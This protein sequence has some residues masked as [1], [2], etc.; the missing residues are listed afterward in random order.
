[1]YFRE[2]TVAG[3]TIIIQEKVSSRVRGSQKRK[4][5]MN[6]TSEAMRKINDRNAERDLTVKLNH[7]FKKGDYHLVLTYRGE[8]PE[9]KK[10]K[11]CLEKF[12]R[13]T[14]AY[15]K[16]NNI[17][18]KYI[19]VTEYAHTRIHHHVVMS[20]IDLEVIDRLWKY[21]Y[22]KPTLLD[23]TGNYQKLAAYLLKETS[24][25]FRNEDN[26]NKR[27]YNC[28][29]NIVTPETKRQEMKGTPAADIKPLKG[30]YVDKDSIRI[31]EHAILEADCREYILVSLDEEPRLKGW[32]KGKK[33]KLEGQHKIHEEE[34]IAFEWFE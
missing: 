10:A 6:V 1:M 19:T 31:Y 4:S 18:F 34:Q 12:I 16:R 8:A 2:I 11:G 17:E 24:K 25:T 22:E 5:R 7:N 33:I 26:P 3:K 9:L 28:S 15:A 20:A 21:G 32:N 14:R 29:R 27:R 23:D 30:Y 13:N